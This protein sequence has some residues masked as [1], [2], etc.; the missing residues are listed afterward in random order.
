[1]APQAV[2]GAAIA[3]AG[4]NT[5]AQDHAQVV[6]GHD[7]DLVTW[8]TAKHEYSQPGIW[9][10]KIDPNDPFH[11]MLIDEAGLSKNPKAIGILEQ[12][13]NHIGSAVTIDY[14][15]APETGLGKKAREAAREAAP[16]PERAKGKAPLEKKEK[17]FVPTGIRFEPK[18][19]VFIVDGFSQDKFL[20]NA[21]KVVAWAHANGLKTYGLTDAKG[22][23][24]RERTRPED[25]AVFEIEIRPEDGVYPLP[26][27]A[28]KADGAAW[29]GECTEPGAPASQAR[30]SFYPDGSRSFESRPDGVSNAI[31]DRHNHRACWRPGRLSHPS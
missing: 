27:M 25:K 20:E 24:H 8:R 12:M 11:K 26:Y 21:A 18:G 13:G 19:K 9:G 31:F 15:H 7:P 10:K 6:A 4:L 28:R 29:E 23:F 5:A 17:S 1:M 30:Q 16:A 14:F 2:G 22:V 3:A